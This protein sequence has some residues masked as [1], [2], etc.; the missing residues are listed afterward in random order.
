MFALSNPVEEAECTAQ[1]AYDW[2]DGAAVYASGTAFAPVRR[3]DGSTFLPG[4]C[5]NCLVFPGK[6]PRS[7]PDHCL[8]CLRL[9]A[10]MAGC[11]DWT[12]MKASGHARLAGIMLG[13]S[14]SCFHRL[15]CMF[16]SEATLPA[17][18]SGVGLGCIA[19]GATEVTDSM[20]L[21][22][23]RGISHK[24]TAEEFE[25]ESVLPRIVRLRCIYCGPH[26]P[27]KR[28]A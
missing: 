16:V 4:Q 20:M 7:M 15:L 25:R 1:Q 23:A 28:I 10:L 12:Y 26:D 11:W 27:Y 8:L 13:A 21:A 2:T 6:G 9:H 18:L 19:A 3:K 17:C 14:C 22:A 24:L 5:N